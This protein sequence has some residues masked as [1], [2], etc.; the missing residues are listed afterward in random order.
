MLEAASWRLASELSRRHPATTRLIRAHPGGGMSDCLWLLPTDGGPGDIRLDRNGTIQICSRFDGRPTDF[1]PTE[2]DD[3]LRAEPR[4]FL[5]MLEAEAGL[6]SPSHVPSTTARTLVLR[7]LAAIACTAVK[8][9]HPLEVVPGFIDTA[10]DY[11]GGVNEE[12]LDS[13]PIEPELLEL[14][15]DDFYGEPGY[16]FWFVYRDDVPILAFEQTHAWAWTQHHDIALP[17]LDLH[18][19]SRRH[20]LITALK[21]L[22][23]VDN[24]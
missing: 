2:W 16:R 17:V 1:A 9:V 20:V 4:D 10:G 19:E 15:E 7:V 6:V 13:F 3:Y 23:R 12:A 18:T 14:Q 11:G 5:A 21:L 24:V 22:Q 8:S